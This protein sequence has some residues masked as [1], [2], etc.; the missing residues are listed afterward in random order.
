MR[1]WW[2]WALAGPDGVAP[3]LMVG[4]SASVKPRLHDPVVQ[5]VWQPVVSCKQTSNRLSNWLSNWLE[6]RL[7]VCIHDTAGCQT[8]FYNR[9][10]NWLYTRYSRLSNWLSN[11]FD[12]WLYCVYKHLP[13]CQTGLTIG[14]TTCCIVP[15]SRFIASVSF[16][17]RIWRYINFY[18]ILFV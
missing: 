9:F 5:P 8:G 2:R 15:L 16:Y 3:S 10:D 14:L 1:G 11:G 6:N 17:Q 18:F 7:N 12:N 13:G 4:V